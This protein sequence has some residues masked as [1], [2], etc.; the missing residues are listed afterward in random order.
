[1]GLTVIAT[2]V[3]LC[4][5]QEDIQQ[6][7]GETGTPLRN[8]PEGLR[9]EGCVPPSQVEG[10]NNQNLNLRNGEEPQPKQPRFLKFRSLRLVRFHPTREE[11]GAE[12]NDQ[13][14]SKTTK[15]APWLW[16]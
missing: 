8:G 11:P 9:R 4:R 14:P 6:G 5:A 10:L 3:P 16:V 12:I 13:R 7:A 15:Q 2:A 1:V